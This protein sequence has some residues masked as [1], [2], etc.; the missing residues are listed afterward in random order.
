[1]LELALLTEKECSACGRTYPKSEF[2][3]QAPNASMGQ[4]TRWCSQC[5][6]IF[7]WFG[8]RDRQ[9]FMD[10]VFGLRCT[11]C[12][13]FCGNWGELDHI[14]PTTLGGTNGLRNKQLLCRPCNR[15]KRGHSERKIVWYLRHGFKRI[16]RKVIGR[17]PQIWE[18]AKVNRLQGLLGAKVPESTCPMGRVT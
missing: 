10:N 14:I 13:R 9:Q 5:R 8:H 11:Y 3:P 18:Q 7:G 2:V 4:W 17:L 16:P 6:D 12:K 15:I 1:M